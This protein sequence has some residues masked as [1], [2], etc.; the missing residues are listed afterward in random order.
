M[1]ALASSRQTAAP[2]QQ[3]TPP[4]SS[5]GGRGSWDFAVPVNGLRESLDQEHHMSEYG[6]YTHGAHQSYSSQA[7]GFAQPVRSPTWGSQDQGR[8]QPVSDRVDELHKKKSGEMIASNT[9]QDSVLEYYKTHTNNKRGPSSIKG[10]PK[11]K[12]SK[13]GQSD[14]EYDEN[15]WIHRDKLKEIETRELE[16]AG[17]R[18]GRS[19]R[20]NSRSQSASRRARDRTNSESTEQSKNGDERSEPRKRVSTIP[21]G[22]EE[23]YENHT[24]SPTLQDETVEFQPTSSKANHTVRPSTSRIP[25]PK[26]SGI[27]VPSSVADRDAPLPRSR[28]GSTHLNGESIATMGARVRSGSVGSQVL[29]DDYEDGQ[30]RMMHHGH[31]RNTSTGSYSPPKSPQKSPVKK[32]AGKQNPSASRKTSVQKKQTKSRTTS[33]TSPPNKRP[34]TSGGMATRPTTAHRPEG[35]APWI[36][37]MYKPDP[38]LP[39]DQQIIPTHAKRMQQEQWENEGRVGS[40]YDKDFRLL[41][42]DPMMSKRLSQL[43]NLDPIAIEKARE[44]EAWPLPS[45]TK[46]ESSSNEKGDTNTAK[47]PTMEQSAYKLTPT[48]PQGADRSPS[49]KLAPPIVPAQPKPEVTRVAEPKEE[50]KE[51]KGLCCISDGEDDTKSQVSAAAEVEV[52]ADASGGKGQMSVLEA[53]KGVLKL[54]LI[55][56]GLAR[57]LREASKALDRREAHMCVLNEACEE[58]AYKKLVVALCS[59]HKIP[60]IKV[61]DGKQLGEWAGL[62]Q[63][64]R[65]GNP[66][67][68]VNC[69]CVVVKDW[70]EESQERSILLN[71][72]QTEQ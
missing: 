27:P 54:A 47:S 9:D 23:A 32:P 3:L 49:P 52:S 39:P 64:D 24:T 4:S 60:L 48:I 36:A 51:K 69:S 62:C 46:Q 10:K 28:A 37:S 55:H 18:V 42:D 66:R 29:L 43:A 33:S 7:N 30:E 14:P 45:P 68:V 67:K 56:D 59:E 22:D 41:N 70:G 40:M 15:N 17:F 53:L 5:H 13:G 61:P 6:A 11:K 12:T 63:I 38:R 44:E 2:I 72:F 26:T 25:L 35:E 20:S 34:G 58:E 57:G 50:V 1:A 71:Y 8:S 16:E 19:S 21:A 65:E 31:R